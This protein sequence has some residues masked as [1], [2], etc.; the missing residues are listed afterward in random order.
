MEQSARHWALELARRGLPVFPIQ[1]NTKDPYL[2]DEC[3]AR[4]RWLAGGI[5]RATTD[6]ALIGRWFDAVPEMN[7]AVKLGDGVN[8]LDVDVAN[9]KPGRETLAKMNG[10]IPPTLTVNS[11]RDGLHIYLIGEPVGQRDLGP[12]INVRS[13]GGY[14]IGPG[15]RFEGRPYTVATDLPLA[16]TPDELRAL[17]AAPAGRADTISLVEPD[18]PSA[19]DRAVAMLLDAEPAIEGFGGDSGTYKMACRVRDLGLSED[20]GFEAMDTFW[21]PRCEPPW[22]PETLRAKVANAYEYARHPLGGAAPEAEF[23]PIPEDLRA[24][25]PPRAQEKRQ[26][27]IQATPYV[28]VDPAS[29]PP[30]EWIYGYHLARKY[31]SA[32]VSPGGIGKSS[33]ALAEAVSIATGRALLGGATPRR[34]RVWYWNGEDPYDEL[35]RRIQAIC[36]HYQIDRSEIE[37]WLFVN[38]GRTTPL[39][40]AREVR[41]GLVIQEPVVAEIMREVKGNHIDVFCVDPFVASHAVE[42]KDN[43]KIEAVVQ[44]WMHIAESGNCA[45]DLIHHTRKT[46]GAEVT[47]EDARG[48]T[49]L[50]NKARSV[51]ALNVMS[52]E[53]SRKV[54]V[55]KRRSYFRIDN[56]K[57][58]LAPPSDKANWIQ[59][60]SV[61]LG[62]PSGDLPGDNIGVATS[63]VWPDVIAKKREAFHELLA[64]I[65]YAVGE[66]TTK[67]AALELKEQ[68]PLLEHVNLKEITAD[69]KKCFADP[70][71]FNG[72]TLM[73]EGGTLKAW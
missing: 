36:L 66:M 47:A 46:G 55:L 16:A 23:E 48:A 60:V 1:P 67:A 56:A 19:W 54:H 73:E 4:L 44:Q 49:A 33:L 72:I 41:Q 2:A 18:P 5:H 43:T 17:L 29:I 71:T 70:I 9:G 58:N 11:A 51:R 20:L 10:S 34:G 6:T 63:W 31:I 7:Y 8:G 59:L 42:E 50:V 52:E 61:S 25:A 24:S 53:D 62:N 22:E 30:R 65:I 68:D 64:D 37:G 27:G 40:I 35:Q 15:S 69:L 12:G 57:Q 39:V 45:V 32:T 26:G 38:S 28:W 14:L 13:T 21:N 3:P